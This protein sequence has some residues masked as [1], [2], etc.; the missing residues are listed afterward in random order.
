RQN[1]K[2]NIASMLGDKE[3]ASTPYFDKVLKRETGIVSSSYLVDLARI[4]TSID[5]HVLTQNPRN[6]GERELGKAMAKTLYGNVK[7]ENLKQVKFEDLLKYS[8][9]NGDTNWRSLL[10]NSIMG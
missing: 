5:T 3:Y 7:D 9:L 1:F 4:F 2:N 8:G 6:E 10:R